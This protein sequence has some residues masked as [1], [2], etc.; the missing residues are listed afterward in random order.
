MES[1]DDLSRFMQHIVK[2]RRFTKVE[3]VNMYW[4]VAA[5]IARTGRLAFI[6]RGNLQWES[7]REEGIS[8][9][10][11]LWLKSNR[12]DSEGKH[13]SEEPVRRYLQWYMNTYEIWGTTETAIDPNDASIS[14]PVIEQALEKITS[15]TDTM[16]FLFSVSLRWY[17]ALY[18]LRN[19]IPLSPSPKREAWKSWDCRQIFH[20]QEETTSTVITDEHISL[21]LSQFLK[22]IDSLPVSIRP[23]ILTAMNW[24]AKADAY[25]SGIN[26]FVNYWQSI[27]LLGNWF[28]DSWISRKTREDKKREILA[29]LQDIDERNCLHRIRE[30]NEIRDPP[31]RPKILALAEIIADQD[32]IKTELFDPD[33]KTGMS[34]N[35]IRNEIVHGRL[36][37]R[38]FERI[39]EL[40]PRLLD[41]ARILRDIILK[42]IVKAENIMKQMDQMIR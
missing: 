20:S 5:N 17:P 39:E 14:K 30:C 31:A 24:H 28:Y 11:G 32:R 38:D 10:H 26:R 33:S 34:L 12:Y 13:I 7:E 35:K 9:E 36:S 18:Q 29:L 21:E 37:E 8:C 4:E 1:S 15:V 3:L 2:M 42:S 22:K 25:A 6:I 23:V 16:A 40:R 41:A 19:H 27:E